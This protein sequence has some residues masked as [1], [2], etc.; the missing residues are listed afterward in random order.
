VD[1]EIPDGDVTPLIVAL[2]NKNVPFGISIAKSVPPEVV[3]VC[4]GVPVLIKPIQSIDVASILAHEVV[5]AKP[6]T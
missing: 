4:P 6:A 1:F 5:K 2:S 3:K